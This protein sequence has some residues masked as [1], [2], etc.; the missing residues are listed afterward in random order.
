M[1]SGP[2]TLTI[3]SGGVQFSAPHLLDSTLE[4]FMCESDCPPSSSFRVLPFVWWC[5]RG[6]RR[7]CVLAQEDSLSSHF[8]RSLILHQEPT[9][10]GSAC[11][12]HELARTQVWLGWPRK[13]SRSCW[14]QSVR[15]WSAR[16]SALLF[17]AKDEKW[18]RT[19]IS[20]LNTCLFFSF[21]RKKFL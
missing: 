17:P 16:N 9:E 12:G 10:S 3:S 5:C 1:L 15:K 6:F 4:R 19:D 13:A 18:R 7:L 20:H 8:R 21:K 11:G 2:A 14:E